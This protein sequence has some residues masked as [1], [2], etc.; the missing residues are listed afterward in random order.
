MFDLI[1]PSAIGFGLG[2]FLGNDLAK[3]G[4]TAD[5]A[6][7]KHQKTAR[8]IF[9][10]LAAILT[11]LIIIDRSN[12]AYYVP[13]LFPHFLSLYIQAA[14]DNVLLCVGFFLFGLLFLLELSGWSS[15]KRRNQLLVGLA[16]I[17]FCLSVLFYLF[18]PI[19]NDVGE[20][21]I[22]DGV[23]IQSTTVTCAPASI[24]TLARLSGK[25]PE[26]TEKEVTKLTR[27][28]RLGTNTLAEIAAMK[29]LGLNPDYH[30]DS[31]LDDLVNRKQ[32]ALLH[33]KQRW[34]SQQ[35]PHAVVLM[36]I[37]ME[38]EELILGNPLSGI[39]TKPFSEL[40]GYWFGE[41]IFIN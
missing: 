15:K 30:H 7:E 27:T 10:G 32:M 22:V 28:N 8:I 9:I 34:L 35:F 37:D 26:I 23:V 19:V 29:K 39:E 6:L 3:K 33:V 14:F 11:V 2:G 20:L 24:A 5:N 31:T 12:V 16:A 13:Q 38:K 40:E 4:I 25:H 17:T 21:K 41:A 36:D 1:L 18:S